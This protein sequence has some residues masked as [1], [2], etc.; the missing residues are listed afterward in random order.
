VDATRRIIVAVAD[1]LVCGMPVEAE[2]SP[3]VNGHD[4]GA[5][6]PDGNITDSQGR[7]C[8]KASLR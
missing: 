7:D 2:P 4:N 8:C 3:L 5:V 1:V 6:Q